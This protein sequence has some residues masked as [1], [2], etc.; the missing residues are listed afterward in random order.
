METIETLGERL[1]RLRSERG[2]TQEQL[3]G[4]LHVTRQAVAKWESD[5]GTPDVDNLVRLA[6][7]F[8]VSLDTLVGRAA[9]EPTVPQSTI[10]VERI[11]A[12][13]EAAPQPQTLWQQLKAWPHTRLVSSFLFL[14]CFWIWFIAQGILYDY[15]DESVSWTVAWALAFFA[16]ITS[17]SASLANFVRYWIERKRQS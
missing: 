5:N 4:L 17:F 6:D 14:L 13:A 7:A 15:I 1:K 2:L 12:Q 16:M 10:P 11:G 9:E 8:G 3:A